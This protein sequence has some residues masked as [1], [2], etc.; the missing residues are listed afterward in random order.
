MEH[1]IHGKPHAIISISK[2]AAAT[3]SERPG[4]AEEDCHQ[5][6]FEVWVSDILRVSKKGDAKDDQFVGLCGGNNLR[7]IGHDEAEVSG[8]VVQKVLRQALYSI[9]FIFRQRQV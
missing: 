9:W 4:A 1:V 6:C 3:R 2:N 8:Y 7:Q 5:A